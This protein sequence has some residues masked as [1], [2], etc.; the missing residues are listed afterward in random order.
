MSV[1][2][3][4]QM[5][6]LTSG[7]L[8]DAVSAWATW[9]QHHDE[10]A[11]IPDLAALP[12]WLRA[13]SHRDRDLVL[14]VL[15]RKGS[16]LGDD[17]PTAAAVLIWVLLPG[18]SLIASRLRRLSPHIDQVVASQLWLEVRALRWQTTSKVAATV[19]LNTRKGVLTD[20]GVRG[21]HEAAWERCVVLDPTTPAWLELTDDTAGEDPAAEL[22]ALLDQARRDQ[23]ITDQQQAL[24]VRLAELADRGSN[25]RCGSKAGIISAVS[26]MVVAA[27]LGASPR[28]IRRHTQRTVAALTASYAIPA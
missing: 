14:R 21:H 10:L 5:T 13:A 9:V 11:P 19:L 1:T 3:E 2:T 24:L 16:T 8:K 25:P 17:E 12:A 7:P 18:A 23:V 22:A 4:L 26:T 15:A 20:L 28:T 27:E 6:D